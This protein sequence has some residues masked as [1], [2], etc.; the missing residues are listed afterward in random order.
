M[1]DFEV[2]WDMAGMIIVTAEDEA[3]AM[4]MVTR[5]PGG[6]MALLADSQARDVEA[7]DAHEINTQVKGKS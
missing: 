3:A 2:A 6:D 7:V 4:R 1:P 5:Y